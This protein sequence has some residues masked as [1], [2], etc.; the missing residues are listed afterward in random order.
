[1]YDTVY[2]LDVFESILKLVWT[3]ISIL[4]VF[5]LLIGLAVLLNPKGTSY[6]WPEKNNNN[7]I[8]W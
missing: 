5:L 6:V 3:G 7:S 4:L 1:M 2:L 8:M